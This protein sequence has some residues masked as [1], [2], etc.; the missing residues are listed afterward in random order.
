MTAK[1]PKARR[2]P[3][4]KNLDE[5]AD[6]LATHDVSELPGK[7]VQFKAKPPIRHSFEF[8]INPA[9]LDA[10]IAHGQAQGVPI[11]DL[12]R[13]WITEGLDREGSAE[14]SRRRKTR[15]SA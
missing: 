11:D 9:L 2:L 7:E 15:R 8:E 13:R 1:L 4:F 6:F 3:R 14:P 10:L 12:V 5:A